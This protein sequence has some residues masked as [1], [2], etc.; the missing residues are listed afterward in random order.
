MV[1]I[2][3]VNYN[4]YNDTIECIKSIHRCDYNEYKIIVVDNCSSDF[5]AEK[6]EG[7][8]DEFDFYLIKSDENGGF[9]TGNNIGIRYALEQGADYVLLLNNDTLVEP[10]FLRKLVKAY[11]K[12]NKC[13]IAIGKIYYEAD[14][15]RIWYAGGSLSK[16]T[17]RNAHYGYNEIDKGLYDKECIVTFATGCMMLISRAVL[18]QVGLLSEDYFMYEEDADYCAKVSRMGY[19]I[20]YEPGSV[21]YHKVSSSAEKLGDLQQY[22]VVRNKLI[23]IKNNYRGLASFMAHIVCRLQFIKRCMTGEIKKSNYKQAVRAYKYGETG[24]RP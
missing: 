15:Q 6:L 23:M 18:E 10:D 11:E 21:V 12:H 22:Y 13:G 20:I 24:R 8:K 9:A 3:L 4:G 16:L 19:N 7:C 17:G 14:R 2:I 1:A 5:S